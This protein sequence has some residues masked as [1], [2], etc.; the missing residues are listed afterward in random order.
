MDNR[1]STFRQVL[2]KTRLDVKPCRQMTIFMFF[3]NAAQW[4]LVT[5][6]IQKVSRK[7]ILLKELSK[8]F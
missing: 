3:F 6:Q 5:F 1:K 2:S 7:G 4:I 8:P